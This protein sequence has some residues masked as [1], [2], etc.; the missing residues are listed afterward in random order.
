MFATLAPGQPVAQLRLLDLM[1]TY[2]HHVSTG[3]AGGPPMH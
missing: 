3:Q 1:R 2:R